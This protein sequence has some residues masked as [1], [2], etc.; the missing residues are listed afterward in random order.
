MKIAARWPAG[1]SV[2]LFSKAFAAIDRPAFSGSERNFAFLA[3]F[4]AYGFKHCRSA[5]ISAAKSPVPASEFGPAK[6]ISAPVPARSV[7]FVEF[8]HILLIM[9]INDLIKSTLFLEK[10]QEQ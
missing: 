6:I 2:F 8:A 1:I 5:R 3:A 7:V 9:I 10:K 4:G